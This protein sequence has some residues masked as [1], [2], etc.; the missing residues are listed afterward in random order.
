MVPS[1]EKRFEGVASE[2]LCSDLRDLV[3]TISSNPSF[4]A[5]SVFKPLVMAASSSGIS[6]FMGFLEERLASKSSAE[7]ILFWSISHVKEGQHVLRD[8]EKML[9]GFNSSKVM[10][11]VIVTRESTW[12]ILKDGKFKLESRPKT[13]ITEFIQ[14][15]KSLRKQLHELLLPE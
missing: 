15:N 14:R 13:R 6:P 10:I 8:L 7:T 11:Y 12:P 4:H 2:Y 1:E 9:E 5:P 3:F